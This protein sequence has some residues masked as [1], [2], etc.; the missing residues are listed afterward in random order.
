[1]PTTDFVCQ[2]RQS[3]SETPYQ[4]IDFNTDKNLNKVGNLFAYKLRGPFIRPLFL[5]HHGVINVNQGY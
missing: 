5:N 1:M 3:Y 2:S 4:D